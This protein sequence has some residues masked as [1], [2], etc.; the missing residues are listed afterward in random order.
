MDI[1][2]T[3]Q[4][5][6]DKNIGSN[7][8]LEYKKITA[9]DVMTCIREA[10]AKRRTKD[11]GE[12]AVLIFELEKHWKKDTGGGYGLSFRDWMNIKIKTDR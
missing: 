2:K 7:Q 1:E 4:E 12:V 5:I 8:E 6:F 9:E 11:N 10:I 3:A